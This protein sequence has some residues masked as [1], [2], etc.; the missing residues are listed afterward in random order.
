MCKNFANFNGFK[1]KIIYSVAGICQTLAL[2]LH[3]FLLGE[4]E[5]VCTSTQTENSRGHI[6]A[7]IVLNAIGL[8]LCGAWVTLRNEQKKDEFLAAW[9]A[10]PLAVWTIKVAWIAS[11]A[12]SFLFAAS[13]YGLTIGLRDTCSSD[14]D[15]R[16]LSLTALLLFT[17]GLA[18]GHLGA[19]KHNDYEKLKPGKLERQ[20][21]DDSVPEADANREDEFQMYSVR[22]NLRF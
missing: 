3:F 21:A 12:L 7:S 17:A 22:D 16:G 15:G 11:T 10:S 6:T 13:L 14:F 18:S 5:D 20:V 9:L 2:I 4:L 19:K 8:V 1:S